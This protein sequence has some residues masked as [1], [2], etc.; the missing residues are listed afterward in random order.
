MSAY[1]LNPEHFAA[2]AAFA[3]RKGHT[4]VIRPFEGAHET[5]SCRNIAREL[6]KENI[7]SVNFRY[8]NEN[9]SDDQL[10]CEEAADLA[11]FFRFNPPPLTPLDIISMCYCLEYQSNETDNY[12]ET[13]ACRQLQWILS[14]A[15]RSLPGFENAIRD[16]TIESVPAINMAIQRD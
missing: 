15:C 6:A 4:S 16:F 9:T 2:L 3:M 1:V 7:R 8:K 11:E 10:I 5:E 12:E 13:D 14:D